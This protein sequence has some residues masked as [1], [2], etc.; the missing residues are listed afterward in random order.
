M[1]HLVGLPVLGSSQAEATNFYQIR[2]SR[3]T[4]RSPTQP[5][6]DDRLPLIAGLMRR[7]ST[8]SFANSKPER[9][10]A[11]WM[12]P[13]LPSS[14]EEVFAVLPTLLNVGLRRK[15]GGR[16]SCDVCMQCHIAQGVQG[17]SMS[18]WISLVFLP[19]SF[20]PP[21]K[22]QNRQFAKAPFFRPR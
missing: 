2:L 12:L 18:A 11:A 3:K 22:L 1:S 6:I 8:D 5:R 7:F 15:L 14:P 17:P 21:S 20:F 10:Q 4:G 13:I 19:E 9:S 16:V